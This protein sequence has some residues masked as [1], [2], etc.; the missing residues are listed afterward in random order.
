LHYLQHLLLQ[1]G[2]SLRLTPCL[3]YLPGFNLL[4]LELL[5]LRKHFR[6]AWNIAICAPKRYQQDRSH[7]RNWQ[8]T[9]P[10]VQLGVS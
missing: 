3:L 2:R 8:R 10:A 6:S 5:L 1:G 7:T 4:K 9:Q